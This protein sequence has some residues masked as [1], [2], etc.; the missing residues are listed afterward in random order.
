[1]DCVV[2]TIFILASN[3]ENVFP[4]VKEKCLCKVH[5]CTYACVSIIIVSFMNKPC[6]ITEKGSMFHNPHL[7]NV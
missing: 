7:D 2:V 3:H 4:T 6:L 5:V 1:M